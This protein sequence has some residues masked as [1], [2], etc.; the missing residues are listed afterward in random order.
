MARLIPVGAQPAALLE[1]LRRRVG[2]AHAE[3]RR[4]LVGRRDTGPVEAEHGLEV[5]VQNGQHLK[6]VV[7]AGSE[8]ASQGLQGPGGVTGVDGVGEIPRRHRARLPQEGLELLEVDGRALAVGGGAA[9]RAGPAD[10]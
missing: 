8:Q 3:A 1:R 7:G 2:A 5:A 10:G 6:R 4:G 9:R